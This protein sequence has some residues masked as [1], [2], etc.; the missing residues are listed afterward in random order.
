MITDTQLQIRKHLIQVVLKH[1][2]AHGISIFVLSIVSAMLLQTIIS[3]M[4]IVVI[5]V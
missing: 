1:I 3:K 2:I 4:H 5:V